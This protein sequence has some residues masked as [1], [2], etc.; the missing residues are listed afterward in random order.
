ML[1][2]VQDDDS[3]AKPDLISDIYFSLCPADTCHTFHAKPDYAVA[4]V[5][6]VCGIGAAGWRDGRHAV[7]LIL[8]LT[9]L[10]LLIYSIA[11]M[12]A[13]RRALRS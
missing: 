1:F 7:G 5:G 3:A 10:G 12:R 11:L 4:Q 8:V 6:H 13:L 2:G 9:I